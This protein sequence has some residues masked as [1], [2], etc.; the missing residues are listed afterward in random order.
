M[1][2]IGP[3]DALIVVDV[4]NDFCAGGALAVPNAERILENVNRLLPRFRHVLATKD[5]HPA[6]H[7]SFQAQG[8]PWP[9]HCLQGA[10]GADLH[11]AL[12]AKLIQVVIHKGEGLRAPGYSGF[13]AT[14]LAAE[15]R[16]RGVTRVFTCGLATDYCVRATTLAARQEGFA[17]VAVTDA[18]AAVDVNPGDGQRALGEMQAAG[19]DL[20]T[21]E[22]V[23]HAAA[24]F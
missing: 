9:P 19:A 6:N 3:D 15:L 12:D 21:T 23:G 14:E 17:A 2:L 20:A 10:S 7:A 22:D 24:S 16:R 5:W 18:M 13:E 1:F 8:G 4:Q 11:P